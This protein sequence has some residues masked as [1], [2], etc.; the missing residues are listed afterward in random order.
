VLGVTFKL[1]G[2]LTSLYVFIC[3]LAFISD[4]FLLL[5]GKGAGKNFVNNSL[6]NNAVAGLMVGVFTTSTLQSSSTTTSIV[7]SMVGAEMLTVQQ[8][9]PVIM[10][11]NVG[12]TVTSTI[13]SLG[14][15]GNKD[16][17]RR[18][19]AAAT[20]H[21]MFNFLTV[22]VLLPLEVSLSCNRNFT[23]TL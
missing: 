5:A 13:V 4:G 18:A 22:L 12:T 17:F 23:C 11:A 15:R 14:L 2:I 20:V 19:F 8:A 3:A 16:E 10:G 21:D 7:I 9:I 6:F 1:G